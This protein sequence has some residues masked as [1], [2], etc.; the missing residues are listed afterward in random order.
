MVSDVCLVKCL[1]KSCSKVSAGYLDSV[2]GWRTSGIGVYRDNSGGG[3][4]FQHIM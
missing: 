3:I 2:D 4:E 1:S